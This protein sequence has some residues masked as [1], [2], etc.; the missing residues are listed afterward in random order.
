ML[1]KIWSVIY[2]VGLRILMTIVGMPI[3][4]IGLLFKKVTGEAKPFLYYPQHTDK[5]QK[6]NLPKLLWPWDNQRDGAKGDVRGQYWIA[7]DPKD[8]EKL[9][10]PAFMEGNDYLKYWYWLVLR[11]PCNNFSR[12]TRLMSCNVHDVKEH[13]F[14]EYEG[15]YRVNGKEYGNQTVYMHLDGRTYWGHYSLRKLSSKYDLYLRMGWKIEPRHFLEHYAEGDY[16]KAW[17]L[18]TFRIRIKKNEQ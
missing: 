14:M 5:W 15:D 2:I 3:V 8:D 7:D 18:F 4:A 12:F 16:E 9:L 1:E 13:G 11:N 6:V 17:K 10:Y